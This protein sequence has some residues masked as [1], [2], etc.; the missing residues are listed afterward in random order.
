MKGSCKDCRRTEEITMRVNAVHEF[1]A[2]A[3][4]KRQEML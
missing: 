2:G 4:L 1:P 3:G